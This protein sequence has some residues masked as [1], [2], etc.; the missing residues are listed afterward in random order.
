MTVIKRRMIVCAD[1]NFELVK[2]DI[3]SMQLRLLFTMQKIGAFI[4]M[5]FV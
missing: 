4:V 1:F 2:V 5:L 3:N